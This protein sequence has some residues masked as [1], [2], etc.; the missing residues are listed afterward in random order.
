MIPLSPIVQ[1][2]KL[3][4]ASVESP[5]LNTSTLVAGLC[6]LAQT[7]LLA[8]VPGWS[9]SGDN[10]VQLNAGV[11]LPQFAPLC[12]NHKGGILPR[13]SDHLYRRP[14]FNDLDTLL[15]PVAVEKTTGW[16][17]K[18]RVTYQLSS[19]VATYNVSPFYVSDLIYFFFNYTVFRYSEFTNEHQ[20]NRLA[21][22]TTTIPL[23]GNES[24]LRSHG[25]CGARWKQL[26]W[27]QAPRCP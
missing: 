7:T 21:L 9:T 15:I 18:S 3:T 25:S 23:A 20:G 19:N 6:Y 22:C 24:I 14:G 16:T 4:N 2:S 27:I 8:K 11:V 1:I 13:S 5:T 17:A 26:R 12:E 10:R